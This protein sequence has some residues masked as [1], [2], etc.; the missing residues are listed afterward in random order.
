L[1]D[2]CL[3]RDLW[4]TPELD[5][6]AAREALRT[7]DDP[8][9]ADVSDFMA[10]RDAVAASTDADF[11][12]KLAPFVDFDELARYI[13]VDRAIANSDGVLAFYFGSGWGPQNANYYWYNAGERFTLIPWDFDKSLLYPEPN[14]WTDNAPNGQNIVPNWNVVTDGCRGYTCYFDAT[15]TYNGVA[16]GGSYGLNGIE[17]DPFLRR[18]REV[19]YDRQK[20]MAEAFIAGPFSEL[21][22]TAKLEAWRS[23]IAGG[24]ADDPFVDSAHWQ[25]AITALQETLPKLRANLTLMMSGLIKESD[26][27]SADG[28]VGGDLTVDVTDLAAGHEGKYLYVKLLA[29]GSSCQ[30]DTDPGLYTGRGVVAAGTSEVVIPDVKDGVYA[31]CAMVDLDDNAQPSAGDLVGMGSL[32]MPGDANTTWSAL[33]WM[34]L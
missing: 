1:A 19:V 18:L 7:N 33:D 8:G 25:S 22:V 24:I 17:C 21:A 3:Y 28:G 27:G 10:M 34:T 30:A 26:S 11:A 15:V 9:V 13:V 2:A 5:E 6:S 23:Q 32:S 29:G 4:P 14:F 12:A 31:T 20:A 16:H